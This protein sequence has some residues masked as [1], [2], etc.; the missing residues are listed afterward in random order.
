MLI[1]WFVAYFEISIFFPTDIPNPPPY[2]VS[3]VVVVVVNWP[4]P[5][6]SK[7]LSPSPPTPINNPAPPAPAPYCVSVVVVV[8]V[9]WPVPIPNPI[10]APSALVE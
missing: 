5:K 3:V 6:V 9:I 4:V 8:V 10:P 2:C 1:T 7:E